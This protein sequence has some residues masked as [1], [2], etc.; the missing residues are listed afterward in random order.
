MT[1]T[2]KRKWSDIYKLHTLK[3]KSTVWDV[4]GAE[5]KEINKTKTPT[6]FDQFSANLSKAK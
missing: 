1:G 6:N 5:S 4:S 3:E 2:S